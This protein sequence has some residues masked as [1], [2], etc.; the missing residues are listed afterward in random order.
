MATT[1][2]IPEKLGKWDDKE[3]GEKIKR[4]VPFNTLLVKPKAY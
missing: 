2:E 1:Y 3:G 4:T